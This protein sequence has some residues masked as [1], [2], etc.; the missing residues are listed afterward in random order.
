MN[1]QTAK[2]IPITEF[3][4]KIGYQ[5]Q[6]YKGVFVWYQSPFIA[7]EQQTGSFRIDTSQNIWYDYSQ[8]KGG[9]IV[10]LVMHLQNCNVATALQQLGTLF[11]GQNISYF[12]QQQQAPQQQ[13]N[14]HN[15]IIV[16]KVKP[17]TNKALL[18]YLAERRISS[19]IATKYLVEVY[20]C[21][22]KKQDKN[23][24]S[25]GFANDLQG[26]ELRNRL[27]K[28][29]SSPKAPTT[30][31]GS[32]HTKKGVCVFE[33]FMDFLSCLEYY[34]TPT[35]KNDCI[36]LNTAGFAE[37]VTDRVRDYDKVFCFLD[38]DTAGKQV[39]T[40]LQQVHPR[41]KD[42]SQFYSEYKDFNE[43]WQNYQQS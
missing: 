3:M 28:G 37:Q 7:T 30:I 8:S 41:V 2:Q 14:D 34:K 29:S 4:Q 33:G 25:V 13:P 12:A 31:Q 16:K 23:Y 32:T 24:F 27:F 22:Y 26:Y 20:Y 21:T 40:A 11:S 15:K 36:V 19:E 10:D 38:N 5:P 1:S 35:P 18:Q 42:F 17:L 39:V 6:Q 43:F 9:K